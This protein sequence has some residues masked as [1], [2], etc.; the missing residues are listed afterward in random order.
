[1]EAEDFHQCVV[2]V[3]GLAAEPFD[4]DDIASVEGLSD[5]IWAF[6]NG[7]LNHVAGRAGFM[8]ATCT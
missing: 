3:E 1:M 5:V 4:V 2:V 8:Q 7:Q 6:S